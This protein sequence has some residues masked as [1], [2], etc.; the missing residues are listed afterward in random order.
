MPVVRAIVE[1]GALYSVTVAVALILFVLDSVGVYIVLAMV[2]GNFD[3][4]VA[5]LTGSESPDFTDHLHRVQ[6][7]H[8]SDGIRDRHVAEY[9]W[10]QYSV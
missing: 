8:N 6:Y 10:R 4:S 1:S 5:R 9:K 3:S 2:R 7:D